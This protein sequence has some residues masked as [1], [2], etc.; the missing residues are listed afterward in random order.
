MGDATLRFPQQER[1]TGSTLALAQSEFAAEVITQF[2]RATIFAQHVWRQPA[3]EG[4]H[5]KKFQASAKSEA[6]DLE[7][8]VERSG[9]NQPEQERR[10]VQLDTKQVIADHHDDEIADFIDHTDSRAKTAREDAIAVANTI[11]LRLSATISLGARVTGRGS[12]TD[13]YP[14]GTTITSDISAGGVVGTA[15][16]LSIA[17]SRELQDDFGEMAQT[18]DELD[19]PREGRVAFV[20][21]YLHRVLQQDRT[22]LSFDFQ[23]M[24]M[25]LPRKLVMVEGF[26]VEVT[27]NLNQNDWSSYVQPNYADQTIMSISV[28]ADF[29]TNQVVAQF[30][31]TPDAIGQLVLLGDVRPFGPDW[32]TDKHSWY[33]GAKIW[34]GAAPL[35]PEACGELILKT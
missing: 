12:G 11:D 9:S 20:K 26:M 16:P 24:N 6:E 34:Q 29:S 22:L 8:G 19:L 2:E 15:Y 13:A 21:P 17:G 35:R 3:Q 30:L 31:A 7:R 1:G 18:M 10:L 32:I 4:T 5:A 23:S 27:N 25:L 28:S 33:Y 14:S